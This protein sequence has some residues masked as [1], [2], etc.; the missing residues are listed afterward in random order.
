[1]KGHL[2]WN[3]LLARDIGEIEVINQDTMPSDSSSNEGWNK[4]I[5]REKKAVRKAN[6]NC[7][8]LL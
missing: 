2:V 8:R 1:M 7:I 5:K 3:K 4:S 6:E